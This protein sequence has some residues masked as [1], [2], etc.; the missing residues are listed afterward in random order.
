MDKIKVIVADNNLLIREGIR[1]LLATKKDVKIVGEI[2]AGKDIQ[3]KVQDLK[4]DVVIIDYY[5]PGTFSLEDIETIYKSHPGANVLVITTNQNKT[6]IQKVLE[7]GVNNYIFKS[8]DKEEL[9]KAVYATA[10]KE[11]FLCGKV[12]DILL[13][14]HPEKNE[15]LISA[16]L[17]LRETEVIKLISEGNTNSKISEQLNLSV[18]TVSS[19]RKNIL[20][21][22][23]LKN[24][25][26]L[27]MYALKTGIIHSPEK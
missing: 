3:R 17:S 9:L 7:Y 10:K 8:C 26:E 27:V 22:L 24:S 1:T 5:L 15:N 13:K 14:K 4:P 19:H 18:H 25:C 16:N 11:R 23:K 2:V 12:V 20:K 6:D 21:K